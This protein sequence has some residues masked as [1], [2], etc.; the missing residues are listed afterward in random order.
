MKATPAFIV[1][2]IVSFS[3][4]IQFSSSQGI[5]ERDDF[6]KFFE[7]DATSGDNADVVLRADTSLNIQILDSE[8]LNTITAADPNSL[9]SA[10]QTTLNNYYTS[11]TNFVRN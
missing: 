2:A 7:V 1:I 10:Q 4:R 9:T 6:G 11:L 5:F 3:E 8:V